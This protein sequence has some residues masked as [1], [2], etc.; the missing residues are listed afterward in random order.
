[1]LIFY[2]NSVTSLVLH[3]AHFSS[4]KRLHAV[5]KAVPFLECLEIIECKQI[6]NGKPAAIPMPKGST[7]LPFSKLT[8]LVIKIHDFPLSELLEMLTPNQSIE[9]LHLLR[10]QESSD[11]IEAFEPFLKSLS[12]LKLLQASSKFVQKM[13]NVLKL[14]VLKVDHLGYMPKVGLAEE[15][16]I[17]RL[18]FDNENGSEILRHI[19]DDGMNLKTCYLN[20]IPLI[21]NHEKQQFDETL[22]LKKVYLETQLTFI[23]IFRREFYLFIRGFIYILNILVIF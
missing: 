10:I 23:D 16:H 6:K 4:I 19:F 15:I 7:H 11:V 20:E 13:E 14:K 1:M 17:T 9:E 22:H 2:K 5:L 8:K 12:S 18:P 3:Y 21:L